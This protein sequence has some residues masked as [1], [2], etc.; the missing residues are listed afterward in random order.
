MREIKNG[1]LAMVGF[2]GFFVQAAVTRQGPVQNVV[3]FV[4]DPAHNNIF[5]NLA[6][7]G[8]GSA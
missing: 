4:A 3:D 2:L 8:A 7:L 5:Y 1:R 6:H